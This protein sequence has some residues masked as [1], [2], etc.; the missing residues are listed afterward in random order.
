MEDVVHQAVEDGTED[1]VL[2]N[3]IEITRLDLSTNQPIA[4]TLMDEP[5][6]YRRF[7]KKWVQEAIRE[8]SVMDEALAEALNLAKTGRQRVPPP[9]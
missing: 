3:L 2:A 6:F 4:R 5:V 7:F 9:A 8:Q 1:L